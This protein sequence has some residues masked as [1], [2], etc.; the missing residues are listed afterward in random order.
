MHL[1][2]DRLTASLEKLEK[3][4]LNTGVGD[5]SPRAQGAVRICARNPGTVN[6]N[7]FLADVCF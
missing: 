2:L 5:H 4:A 1:S 3:V 7:S 6:K